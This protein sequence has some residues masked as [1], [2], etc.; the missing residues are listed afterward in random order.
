[1]WVT[2]KRPLKNGPALFL[3]LSTFKQQLNSAFHSVLIFNNGAFKNGKAT[4]LNK[5]TA[6]L[7]RLA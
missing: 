6:S 5:R 7:Y 4:H 1:M 2:P 3:E